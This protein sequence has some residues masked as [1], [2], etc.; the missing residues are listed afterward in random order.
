[1]KETIPELLRAFV[2]IF[3]ENND[4]LEEMSL[5]RLKKLQQKYSSEESG[6]EAIDSQADCLDSS[7]QDSSIDSRE[8]EFALTYE[9]E[10][11]RKSGVVRWCG[12]A[13]RFL[14]QKI[15]RHDELGGYGQKFEIDPLA[16]FPE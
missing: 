9:T 4:P 7:F 8:A 12:N 6:T 16:N 1:M 11:N 14:E 2:A 5:N 15:R 13:D 10:H 3:V